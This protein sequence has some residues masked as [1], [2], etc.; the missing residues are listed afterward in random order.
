MAVP[1]IRAF[2]L[3]HPSVKITVLSKPFLKPLFS[4]IK[5]V[6]FYAADVKGKH[7]GYISYLKN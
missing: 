5:N 6:T 1:V 7:K 4:N 2:L 3:Q